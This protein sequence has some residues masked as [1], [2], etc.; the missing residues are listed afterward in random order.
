MKPLSLKKRRFYFY[1]LLVVFFIV[2]P[3]IILYTSGYRL[4][5]GFQLVETGGIYIYSPE[6][7]ADIY[8]DNKKKKKTSV[9]QRELFIQNLKPETYVVYITKEG[10]WPWAKE[11]EVEERK[12]TTAIAFLVPKEPKGETIPRVLASDA[13]LQATSTTP[14]PGEPNPEY[15]KIMELFEEAAAE[16]TDP[17]GAVETAIATSTDENPSP[18]FLATRGH[19]GLWQDDTRV[20]ASWL[21]DERSLPN[22]F[23]RDDVCEETVTV[24]NSVAPVKNIDFYPGREDIVLIAIQNGIYVIEID[25]RKFQNFQPVYKGVDP[26]FAVS[27]STLYIKDTGNLFKLAL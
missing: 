9:F 21:K 5:K 22:Y 8:V 1:L 11:V 16:E 14:L 10:F 25:A 17:E 3:I 15:A 7:G 26:Y 6:A 24:F 23:C 20:M 4:G 12:V 2:I 13:V 19:T 18:S 27:G